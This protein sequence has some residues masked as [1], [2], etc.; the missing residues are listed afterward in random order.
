VSQVSSGEPAVGELCKLVD[1]EA[2]SEVTVAP[3]RGALVTSF[4]VGE[5]ELLYLDASTLNDA[6]KNV[7]GGIPV[8]FP[9]PGK[10]ESDAW[11]WHGRRGALKQHG[12]ARNLPWALAGSHAQDLAEVTLRLDSNATTLAAYPFAFHAELTFSLAGACLS[13]VSRVTNDGA[14]TL[15]FA[16][17]YHP[18]FCVT[19][20]AR[21][22]VD[23]HPTRVFDNVSK[24]T[25]AFTAI[26]LTA[27]EV[28][29]HLLD[30]PS[31]RS[32]L[33]FGDGSRLELRG[34]PDFS[35]WVVWALAGKDFV[36]VEPWTAPGN[37]LNTGEKLSELPPGASHE[38]RLELE[39]FP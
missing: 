24:R 32:A 10:L 39:F 30:H 28:D 16:F 25:G 36:C 34:T 1:A 21:A 22:S 2:R 4:R 26:D 20:K 17:G 18:Y 8:L 3:R 6:S 29:L 15:P 37:A 33:E 35:I 11:S 13:I 14:E 5:R 23:V 38:S 9:T 31:S 12:F 27:P 19:D 7:R